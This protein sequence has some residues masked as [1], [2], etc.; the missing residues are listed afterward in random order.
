M[1]NE[2][3]ITAENFWQVQCW[4]YGKMVWEEEYPNLVCTAGKNDLL[5]KYFKGSSYT[6]AWYVG[7]ITNSPTPT[8][9]VGDTAAQ[10]NGTNGWTESSAYGS[11]VAWTGGTAA[12][13]SIDNSASQAS[14]GITGP[15]SIYGAVLAST[16]ANAGTGGILYGEGAFSSVRSVLNGDTLLV[17]VTLTVS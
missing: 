12:N 11:R 10:I 8:L 4:R 9:A 13:G 6:A 1:D 14:I 16:S 5:T 7:L 3:R 2:F 15:D 17:T